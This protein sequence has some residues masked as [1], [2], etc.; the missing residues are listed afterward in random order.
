MRLPGQKSANPPASPGGRIETGESAQAAA[1]RELAEET[2]LK[3][4]L[5]DAHL[6]TMLHDDRADDGARSHLLRLAQESRAPAGLLERE[7]RRL[8]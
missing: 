8:C 3:A 1:V 5:D 2:G 4:S 6:L 7:N